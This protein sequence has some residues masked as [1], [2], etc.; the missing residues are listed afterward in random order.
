MHDV[1]C[2]EIFN[3]LPWKTNFPSCFWKCVFHFYM[4][5][6]N[7]QLLMVYWQT[8][9]IRK[10]K[11]LGVTLL[12]Y[13]NHGAILHHDYNNLHS[14]KCFL[15]INE[16]LLLQKVKKTTPVNIISFHRLHLCF[17]WLSIMLFVVFTTQIYYYML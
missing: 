6:L 4:L 2:V 5:V 15:F 17:V 11:Q 3:Y 8:D 10:Q 12:L 13:H 7:Y 16:Q 9:R 1:L 14:K